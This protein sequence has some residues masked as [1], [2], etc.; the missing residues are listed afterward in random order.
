MTS[1]LLED[2]LIK[3]KKTAKKAFGQNDVVSYKL[4]HG[5]EI[6]ARVASVDLEGAILTIK[7]P[8]SPQV[9]AH[10]GQPVL[11]LP[12]FMLTIEED[13]EIAINP[14]HVIV[15]PMPTEKQLAQSYLNE[16]SPIITPKTGIIT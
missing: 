12:P 5:E 4:A 9:R 1:P 6:I 13:A 11:M 7:N 8:R 15:G 14:A 10:N 3:K 16:V 2:I